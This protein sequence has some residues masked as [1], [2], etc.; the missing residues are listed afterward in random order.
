[1]KLSDTQLQN[2]T[3][4][5]I[6]RFVIHWLRDDKPTALELNLAERLEVINDSRDTKI[7]ELEQDIIELEDNIDNLEYE[8]K[9]CEAKN[10][11]G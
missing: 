10:Y 11:E 7:Q 3:N 6:L 2:L 5:E 4:E 1:M 8:L 9:R